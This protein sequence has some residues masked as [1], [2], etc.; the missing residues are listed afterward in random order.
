MF[1]LNL[2]VSTQEKNEFLLST[3]ITDRNTIIIKVGL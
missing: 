3:T 1:N 2:K